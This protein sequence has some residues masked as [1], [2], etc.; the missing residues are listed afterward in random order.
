MQDVIKIF[1]LEGKVQHYDWGGSRFLPALLHIENTGNKPFAEYWMG[2]HPNASSVLLIPG[3]APQ[4]VHALVQEEKEKV[5]GKPVYDRFGR[6]PYLFKVLDVKDMLSIQVHPAK[7]AAEEAFAHENSLGVPLT[8][9]HRN[10]KDDNHKPE[11]MVALGDFWLLHGFKPQAAMMEVLKR[12]PELQWLLP[13]FEQQG[14]RGL[15]QTVMEMEQPRLQE[16][17][18]PLLDR[19]LPQYDKGE[20]SRNDE[21]FWAARAAK[22]FNR[23]GK[24]DKG[25]FSVYFFNLVHLQP[26]EAVFQDAGVPH[27]YLEGQNME[28]MANSDN[29]LRGGLTNKHVD[30]PELMKHVRFEET[31][32]HIIHGKPVD[33]TAEEIFPSPAP[34][35][36]LS[37]IHLSPGKDI[38]LTASTAEVFFVYQGNVHVKQG[39]HQLDLQQGEAWL[40]V[41][42]ASFTIT[43]ADEAVLF[44]ATVPPIQ[45]V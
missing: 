28:I 6:L 29:V 18:K 38:A 9:P 35:F 11:L 32:P 27:A 2:G 5:L 31:F 30:V 34:E 3:D 22:T 21:S 16:A 8:A 12:V 1:R 44:R 39:P 14:Y 43:A 41:L 20:L 13:V 26:G 37:R 33:K 4:T 25:I 36:L 23:E 15:Y 42:D 10:Y 7:K 17:L 24:I 19:I 45:P 40:A